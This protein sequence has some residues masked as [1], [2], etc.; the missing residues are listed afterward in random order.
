MDNVDSVEKLLEKQIQSSPDSGF[1]PSDGVDS[2]S[3]ERKPAWEDPDDDK[4]ML[5]YLKSD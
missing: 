2:E 1:D 3:T 4:I 5:V